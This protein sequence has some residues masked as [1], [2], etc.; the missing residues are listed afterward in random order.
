[1][2]QM[3]PMLWLNLYLMFTITLM[4]FITMLFYIKTPAL[5]PEVSK[6]HLKNKLDWKW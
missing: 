5:A 6:P 1:M 2:P 4:I 3:S